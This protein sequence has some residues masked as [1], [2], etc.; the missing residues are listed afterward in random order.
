MTD[1]NQ[2]FDQRIKAL[3]EHAE[4][5]VPE[6]VWKAV[7]ARV[8]AKPIRKAAPW[9]WAGAG[10]AV[11]AATA[12]ALVLSGTFRPAP[13]GVAP[14]AETMA[15]V[16]A[17]AVQT[18]S[19]PVSEEPASPS[20]LTETHPIA[21][22][23]RTARAPKAAAPVV[24]AVP[25]EESAPVVPET[26]IEVATTKEAQPAETAPSQTKSETRQTP[27][28]RKE[29]WSDPFARMAYEDLHQKHTPKSSLQING[30]VGTNDKTM[31]TLRG[32][33]MAAPAKVQTAS[34]KT[35]YITEEGESVYAIPLSFGVGV[36]YYFA[37]RWAL[38]A[39][40]SYSLLSRSFPGSYTKDGVQIKTSNSSIKHNIQYL[41][42]PVNLYFDL[43]STR[44]VH[45]YTFAGGSIEKGLFQ[46]YLIPGAEGME[47]WKQKVP[48]LQGS[49][50]LGL[51]FQMNISDHMGLYLDPSARY[52]FGDNQPKSIRT[53]QRVMFNLELGVRFDL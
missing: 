15:Q 53:Q 49:A 27:A 39:G 6:G 51:G 18:P 30:L 29:A 32:G 24:E 12:L 26:G 7:Q 14:A 17:P 36:K 25:A 5:S 46:K 20:L 35:T 33:M 9:W 38:G 41:G 16:A 8:P 10:L 42:I 34:G 4:E 47:V 52:Y 21:S 45:M 23:H 2:L 1:K 22:V 19:E 31:A 28:T 48:G 44:S 3:L 11:A 13:V 37:E 40:V 50:A 43:L